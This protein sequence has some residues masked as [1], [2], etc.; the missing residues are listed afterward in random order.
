MVGSTL[1]A[2]ASR[3]DSITPT[4][5]QTQSHASRNEHG[6]EADK[7][8]PKDVENADSE[9]KA[10]IDRLGRERPAKFKSIWAEVAFCYSIIASMIMAV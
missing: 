8:S 6:L 5:S 2:V 10:R 9:E 7:R 3:H 1:A 4:L